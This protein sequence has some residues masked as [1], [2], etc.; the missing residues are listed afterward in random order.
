MDSDITRLVAV[1][2]ILLG[3]LTAFVIQSLFALKMIM[4]VLL[5]FLGGVMIA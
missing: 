1:V 5:F 2:F 4:V 3:L